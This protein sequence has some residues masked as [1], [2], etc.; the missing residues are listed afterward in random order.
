MFDIL[1]TIAEKDFNK[2]RFVEE[3]IENSI[4]GWNDIFIISP[5]AIPDERIYMSNQLFT[6]KDVLDFDFSRI[7]ME[8][9]RGWYRQQFIKLFQEVT[10]DNYLVI[11]A[12]AYINKPL[13][14]NPAHPD[15]Y[16]GKDQHHLPYFK[17]LKD[18]L[19]LDRV[20]PHSFIA[21]MMFF[22]RG[23]IKYMLNE[24]K[25]DKQEFFNVAVDK[26]NEIDNGSGFSEYE[27]YGNYVTKNWPDFYG[28]KSIEVSHQW[29]KR[30]WTDNE[31]RQYIEKYKNTNYNILT[32]HSWM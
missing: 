22:K 32:M 10:A 20:Y 2:L 19:N 11:D 28:Y 8:S 17:F 24:L 14:I 1:I 7:K 21:E 31:I 29:K 5:V 18:V 9:R 13:E 23:V 12:D 16:L 25:M 27:M 3:S 30:E 15:F 26:I 6:D 4:E